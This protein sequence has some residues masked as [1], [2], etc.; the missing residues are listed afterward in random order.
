VAE[1]RWIA[2]TCLPPESQDPRDAIR[3]HR[4][5]GSDGLNGCPTV[6]EMGDEVVVQ[7]YELDAATRAG[8]GIPEGENAVRVPKAVYASGAEALTEGR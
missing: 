8:L 5:R 4:D 3:G 2:G 1:L 7:G 6:F